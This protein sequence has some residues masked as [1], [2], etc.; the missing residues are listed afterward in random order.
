M[1]IPDWLFRKPI[2]N[3]SRRIYN[4][5]PIR[6]IAREKIKIDDKQPNKELAEKMINPY[7]FTDRILKTAFNTALDSHHINHI[8]SKLFITPKKSEIEN[9]Y[10]DEKL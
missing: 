7:Y 9:R 6:E 8:T 4:P 5:K 2:E 3:I 1:I 10:F